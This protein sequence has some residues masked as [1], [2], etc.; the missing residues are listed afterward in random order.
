MLGI[1]S[2]ARQMHP[3]ELTTAYALLHLGSILCQG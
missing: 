3:S 2:I 1:A